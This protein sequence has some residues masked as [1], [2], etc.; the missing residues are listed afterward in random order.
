MKFGIIPI[1]VG[2]QATPGRIAALAERAEAAGVESV[3][4]F[5]HVMVPAEYAWGLIHA[6]VLGGA[7]VRMR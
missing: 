3:W 4:T 7:S 1:N 6:T 2:A 5:E